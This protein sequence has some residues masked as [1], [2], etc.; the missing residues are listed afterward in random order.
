MLI[1]YKVAK[2][3]PGRLLSTVHEL[4]V[5]TGLH[6]DTSCALLSGLI[7]DSLKLFQ[8]ATALHPHNPA[9]LKQV[10]L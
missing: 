1:D 9:N 10:C 4:L 8:Q 3:S 5:S 2:Q 7:Q 6:A